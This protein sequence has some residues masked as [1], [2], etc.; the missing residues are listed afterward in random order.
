MSAAFAIAIS[1]VERIAQLADFF[2][3]PALSVAVA[4]NVPVT[5]PQSIG[6]LGCDIPLCVGLGI[7]GLWAAVDAYAERSSIQ[8]ARCAIC[9]RSGCLFARLENT[10]KLNQAHR[11]LLQE[12]EDLRHL[13]AH[14]F[15]GQAD[16][17]YFGMAR[18]VL[19]AGQSSTLSSGA[20]FDGARVTLS[21]AHLRHYAVC[22]RAVV[23]SLL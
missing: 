17:L 5:M 21:V 18:H 22:S 23:A 9:G 20:V 13:Y 19:H 3:H 7:V 6:S 10:G 15:A 8:R 2:D 14:N 11:P 12:V 4:T 1:Q 16:A